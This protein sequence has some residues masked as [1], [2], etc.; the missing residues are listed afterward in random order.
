VY[1]T[2]LT[3]E[4]ELKR[5]TITFEV[6]LRTGLS[7]FSSDSYKTYELD[8]SVIERAYAF[9]S[10]EHLLFMVVRTTTISR[11]RDLLSEV[12]Q[13]MFSRIETF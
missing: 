7:T 2:N 10:I 4:F 9:S 8:A 6:Y 1:T 11:I 3:K 13:M 5:I 12:Q